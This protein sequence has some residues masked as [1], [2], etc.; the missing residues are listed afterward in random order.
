MHS[1]STGGKVSPIHKIFVRKAEDMS[2]HPLK[3]IL[4][5]CCLSA[6]PQLYAASTTESSTEQKAL[7]LINSLGCKACHKIAGEGGN[8]AAELDN[9]GSRMTHAQISEHL[10]A[11]T[12]P[13]KETLMPSYN[14]SSKEELKLLSE[15][16]YNL[17]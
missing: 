4:L 9:I 6:A 1:L 12:E 15:Y 10:A 14:T 3:L 17:Q 13:K 5:L 16:L 2:T 11:H 7:E 8:L